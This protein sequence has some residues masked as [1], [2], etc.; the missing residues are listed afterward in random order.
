[1]SNQKSSLS[2]PP[3]SRRYIE[4]QQQ[5]SQ[6][7]YNNNHTISSATKASFRAHGKQDEEDK[8]TKVLRASINRR[9]TMKNQAP[10]GV[11]VI[12]NF[13]IRLLESE[14]KEDQNSLF[15]A[16]GLTSVGDRTRSK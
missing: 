11:S 9:Y 14:H 5:E 2:Q 10:Y 7:S 4:P 12:N 1:M 16:D 8:E 13:N 15:L 3:K 6:A